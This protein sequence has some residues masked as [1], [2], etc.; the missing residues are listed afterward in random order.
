MKNIKNIFNKNAVT[1]KK[2]EF[3]ALSGVNIHSGRGNIANVTNV[4][5]DESGRDEMK[6]QYY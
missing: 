3:S 4:K 2:N 6:P 1:V 5:R